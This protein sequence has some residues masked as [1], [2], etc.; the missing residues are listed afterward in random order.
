MRNLA[1]TVLAVAGAT[2][3]LG[4]AGDMRQGPES[5]EPTRG[6]GAPA[7]ARPDLAKQP[8]VDTW[9]LGAGP[10]DLRDGDLVIVGN[11]VMSDQFAFADAWT[12]ADFAAQVEASLSFGG[13][14]VQVTVGGGCLRFTNPPGATT[15]ITVTLSSA[16]RPAFNHLAASI[17]VIDGGPVG[18]SRPLRVAGLRFE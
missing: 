13:G 7:T 5:S 4:C 14:D 6:P 18:R 8:L 1:G 16:G 17:P 11:G 2:L 9:V 15:D 12:V 3:L 10:I